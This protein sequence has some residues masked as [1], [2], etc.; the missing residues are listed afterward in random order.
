MTIIGLSPDAL[1]TLVA[2]LS[3]LYALV[4]K[5][6]IPMRSDKRQLPSPDFPRLLDLEATNGQQTRGPYPKS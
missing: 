5:P 4:G 1:A 3:I 6:I 2:V